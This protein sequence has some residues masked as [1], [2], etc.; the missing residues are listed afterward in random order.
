MAASSQHFLVLFPGSKKEIQVELL[1]LKKA[2]LV[3][4]ALNHKL[5]LQIIRMLHDKEELTVTEIYVKLKL[6]QSV[7]SQHLA[8]LRRAGIVVTRREGKFIYY[9]VNPTRI[10][11]IYKIA[12]SLV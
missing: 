5:R 1:T 12:K 2:D 3:I 10:E 4:R 9:S 8:I 6:E 11:E 7:A